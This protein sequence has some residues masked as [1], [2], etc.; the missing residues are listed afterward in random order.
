MYAWRVTSADGE[1]DAA[2]A[3]VRAALDAIRGIAGSQEK[4]QAA[5]QFSRDLRESSDE[6]SGIRD[7][8]VI[9][10]YQAE[11]L[12]LAP[13]AR[14]VGISKTRAHQIV[15]AAEKAQETG[16]P[17]AKPKPEPVVAAIVTSRKGVLVGRRNDGKPL[18]TFI[19]GE[20]EDGEGPA[21]TAIREVREETGLEV[22]AGP[23]I[24]ERQ[25]PR[26]KRWMTYVA[27]TP[28]AGTDA[29]VGDEDELAEVRWVSL[30]EA[31][32]LMGGTIYEPVHKYL[33]DTL[34]T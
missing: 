24:G 25:H 16:K 32:N 7:G 33:S 23:V 15:K 4:V 34:E 12:S 1:M 21:D 5:G 19:A 11:R 2:R 31:D 13:L 30:A 8:E 17:A 27:A 18:W 29:I 26:T 10:I 3:A 20:R 22:A 6:A 9:S 14:R 28:T